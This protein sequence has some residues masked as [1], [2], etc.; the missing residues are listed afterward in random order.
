MHRQRDWLHI[1]CLSVLSFCLEAVIE[2]TFVVPIDSLD[3]TSESLQQLYREGLRYL[4]ETSNPF[5]KDPEMDDVIFSIY[6][7][8]GQ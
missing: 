4:F 6:T 3:A 8:S 1:S 7:V 2:M 5:F